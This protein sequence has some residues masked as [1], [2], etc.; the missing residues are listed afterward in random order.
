MEELHLSDLHNPNNVSALL[1]KKGTLI[2]EA[3]EGQR[4]QERSGSWELWQKLEDGRLLRVRRYVKRGVIATYTEA[5][6]A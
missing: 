5:D 4:F 6:A 3:S 2:V 1:I